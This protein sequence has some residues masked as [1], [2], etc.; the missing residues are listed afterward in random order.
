MQTNKKL[1]LIIFV[2]GTALVSVASYELFY[3]LTHVYEFDARI[4]TE[5]TTLSSRVDA[6]IE[7][8]YVKEGDAVTKGSLLVALDAEVERLRIAA[9]KVDLARERARVNKLLAEK[10]ALEVNLRSRIATKDEEIWALQIEHKSIQDRLNLAKK[11][12]NRSKILHKKALLSSKSLEQEQAKTLILEGQVNF[13]AAKVRVAERERDEIKASESSID[14]I[15]SELGIA[16]INI[17]KIK[18]LI[19]E[20]E[21]ELKHRSIVSPMDGIIDNIFK[22]EGEHVAEGEKLI[23]LHDKNSF[24]IE[25]N[26]EESQLRYLKVSQNVII[27]IDAYPFDTFLGTVTRIGSV[28]NAQRAKGGADD[29]KASKATQRIP[30]YI[31]LLDPPKTI[32][33]GML[34]EVNI[35]IYD[36]LGF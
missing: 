22:Y 24:W 32:A 26:I 8:I 3:W 29:V 1:R 27:D 33:P 19:K 18:I 36:Q 30:V 12:L 28:T 5:L 21:E 11:N 9:F 16:E 6:N 23:L 34:V 10:D 13:A 20:A 35:Q 7:K 2:L 31:K 4:K 14:V 17:E 15:V 25:A